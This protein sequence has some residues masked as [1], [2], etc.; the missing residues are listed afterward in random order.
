[1]EGV[2]SGVGTMM[3]MTTMTTTTDG[4]FLNPLTAHMVA[5]Y[6]IGG[7]TAGVLFH[8]TVGCWLQVTNISFN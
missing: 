8:G 5:N 4:L 3:A 2:G 1:M 6:A 7:A